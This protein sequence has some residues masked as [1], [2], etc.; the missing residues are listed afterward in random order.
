MMRLQYLENKLAGMT[1]GNFSISYYFMKTKT[2]C[3][4]ISE[5]DTEE[6]VSDARLHRY[7]IRGQ[8]KEFMPFISSVQGWENQPSITELES[9][10]SNRKAL[11][12]QMFSSKKSLSQVEDVLYT[13][14]KVK[15]NFSFNHFSSLGAGQK[16]SKS[17]L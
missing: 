10:L 17:L 6:P 11:G 13:K 16:Q 7:L 12:K 4:K 3:F 1:Q 2:L 15:S 9:L 14:D 5:L 8:W